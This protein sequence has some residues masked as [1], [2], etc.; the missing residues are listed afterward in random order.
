[1]LQN[2]ASDDLMSGGKMTEMNPD[3][4]PQAVAEAS[5]SL[6]ATPI[7]WVEPIDVSNAIVYLVSKI[8]RSSPAPS[9]G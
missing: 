9:S 1:M 6:N 2:E 7:K 3:N 8:S 5:T 4:P